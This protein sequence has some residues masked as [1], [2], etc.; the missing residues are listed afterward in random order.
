MVTAAG[1]LALDVKRTISVLHIGAPKTA[2]H[3]KSASSDTD[4]HTNFTS[5]AANLHPH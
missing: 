5:P 1:V 2:V 3:Y 4:H